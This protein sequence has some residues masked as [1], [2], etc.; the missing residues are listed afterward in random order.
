MQLLKGWG[1][2]RNENMDEWGFCFSKTEKA[3]EVQPLCWKPAQPGVLPPLRAATE[4]SPP[5]TALQDT[6][7]SSRAWQG[8]QSPTSAAAWAVLGDAGLSV[9]R[10]GGRLQVSS[11]TSFCVCWDTE[12]QGRLWVMAHKK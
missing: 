8:G 5:F 12:V 11:A 2:L 6:K 7:L 1:L 9:D 3:S 4:G 10:E